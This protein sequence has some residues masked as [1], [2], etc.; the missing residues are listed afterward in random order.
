VE[1]VDAVMVETVGA[2]T[3]DDFEVTE[4]AAELALVDL[5]L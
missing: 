1:E 5:R 2:A 4:A 3:I